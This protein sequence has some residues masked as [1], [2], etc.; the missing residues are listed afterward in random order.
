M[1]KIAAFTLL[2]LISAFSFSFG[3]SKITGFAV[4]SSLT[5][6]VEFASIA[7]INK[8]TNKPV[9]G[10]MADEKGFFTLSKVAAGEY[11][12]LISFLGFNNKTVDNVLITKDQDLDLGVIKLASSI[13]TLDEVTVTGQRAL[14]EEKVD[15]LVYN[16]DKDLTA[17]GGDASDVLRKVPMLS[18]DLQGNVS[19]QGNA[20]VLVLI[21]NKPSAIMASTVADALKQIPADQIKSV[22]VI[23]SPSAKYDAEGSGG[24]I[25]IITKKNTLEGLT[26]NVDGGVGN[27]SSTL[28]LTGNYRKGKLGITLG[29]NGRFIYNPALNVIEQSTILNGNILKTNQQAT[30]FD[31]GVFGQYNLG[32]DYDLAKNQSLTANV[33]FGVR[34]FNRDQTLVSNSF[35]NEIAAGT[36]SRDLKTKDLSNSID[37]NLDYLHTYKPGQEWTISTQYSQNN[38]TNNFDAHLLN[39]LSEITGQQ[40][41]SNLNTNKEMTV[42]TDYVTPIAKNQS[43]EI[44]AKAIAREVNSNFQYLFAN[45][46]TGTLATDAKHPS[47]FL[48]YNQNIAAAYASYTY[49]TANKYTIKAGLRYEYT[50][51]QA[52]SQESAAIN[53]PAY[54]VLVPSLNISKK[55]NESTTLKLSYNRRIQRPGLQQLNPNFNTANPLNISYGNPNLT[56]EMSNKV[57]FGL[58]TNIKKTYLNIS[59]FTRLHTDDIQQVS[60]RSDTLAGAV[61]TTFMN[62]GKEDNYGTNVFASFNMGSKWTVNTNFDAMYRY[63]EG[64][65]PDLSGTSVLI[66]NA[67]WSFGGRLDVQGQLGKGWAAQINGGGRGVQYGLQGTRAGMFMY[68]V[69]V[70]KEF[71]QKKA[72][73]G[74][75]AENF[76]TNGMV[77]RST[78]NSAQFNQTNTNYIYNSSVRLTFS[79]KI[80]KMSFAAPKRKT[81]SVSNDDVKN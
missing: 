72:S 19:L 81:K 10:T 13:K 49:A 30:A 67:G 29:G 77:M 9:D 24:I 18:V 74:L 53:I 4:D 64:Q 56:P 41:N 12:L 14:V 5:K 54:G 17:R 45:T 3:Q 11:K 36:T 37:L 28:G 50:D 40:K 55:I 65:A 27:R 26:L 47:G 35:V 46:P 62:L 78:L 43:F 32:F 59:V 38:L 22:E 52:K 31:R 8:T 15:R 23:T 61:T 33:R 7:L 48:N 25:N 58:S 16:A 68:S 21:N 71:N 57:E 60:Q 2:L 20:N 63:L 1:K 42:Q 75:A 39:A 44:G 70:R 69:G 76:L 6:A 80:G 51:I 79:Y 34:N 66:T 73:L